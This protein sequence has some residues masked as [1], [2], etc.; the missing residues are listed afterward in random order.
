MF[1]GKEKESLG[2]AALFQK[3]FCSEQQ[4][5]QDCFGSAGRRR[6]SFS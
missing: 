2:E 3:Y 6:I 1:L 5:G 4:R